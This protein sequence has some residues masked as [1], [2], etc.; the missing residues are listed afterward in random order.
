MKNAI[1]A[2]LTVIVLILAYRFLFNPQLLLGSSGALTV[3]PDQWSYSDGLCRPLYETSCVAFKPETI[4]SKRQACNLA[5]TCG[6]NWPGKC[7]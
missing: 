6:T 4:T 7:P 5:R 2:L 3:C 1:I